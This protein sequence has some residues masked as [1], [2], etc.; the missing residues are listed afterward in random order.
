MTQYG[1]TLP[2]LGVIAILAI[3]CVAVTHNAFAED[4]PALK[5]AD[6]IHTVVS[7]RGKDPFSS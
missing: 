2:L 5:F 1:I 4:A 6:D 3:S 7:Q